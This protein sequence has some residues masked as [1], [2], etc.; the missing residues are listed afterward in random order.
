MLNILQGHAQIMPPFQVLGRVLYLICYRLYN[1]IFVA[2][3][4]S[5]TLRQLL[6]AINLTETLNQMGGQSRKTKGTT[7]CVKLV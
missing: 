4:S 6:Y 7:H 2:L 3:M 5:P 1:L